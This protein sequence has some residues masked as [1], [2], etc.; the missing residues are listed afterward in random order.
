MDNFENIER[1]GQKGES[2][3]FEILRERCAN[4]KWYLKNP[5]PTFIIDG[6][7][8]AKGITVKHA[9]YNKKAKRWTW[10]LV[11]SK[12]DYFVCIAQHDKGSRVYVVPREAVAGKKSFI[13]TLNQVETGRDNRFKENW[14]IITGEKEGEIKIK[15]IEKLKDKVEQCLDLFDEILSIEKEELSE[16]A[17]F[18]FVGENVQVVFEGLYDEYQDL[19]EKLEKMEGKP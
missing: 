1:T 3:V 10:N 17:L 4:I 12:G 9:N 6:I 11:N 5:S 18:T 16:E 14:K 2:Y 19:I 7:D 8:G 13:I 15:T